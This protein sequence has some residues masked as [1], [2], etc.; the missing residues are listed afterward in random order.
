MQT[1]SQ[2]QLRHSCKAW[3]TRRD[4]QATG[5]AQRKDRRILGQGGAEREC[6]SSSRGPKAGGHGVADEGRR[7]SRPAVGAARPRR[8]RIPEGTWRAAAEARR[9]AAHTRERS[10]DDGR[11]LAS[12]SRRGRMSSESFANQ[13]AR[14]GRLASICPRRKSRR[15]QALPVRD[16]FDSA[17]MKTERAVERHRKNT[18][19]AFPN[20]TCE[21]AIAGFAGLTHQARRSTVRGWPPTAKTYASET[22][23]VSA[24]CL[25]QPPTLTHET[26]ALRGQLVLPPRRME[27]TSSAGARYL[28]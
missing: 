23:R 2:P 27:S 1:R 24:G 8:R 16:M 20:G 6:F 9:Q 4:L 10:L 19:R 28:A 11:S 21:L 13:P 22:S 26:H 3:A 18:R 7:R 5:I 12:T 25:R 15:T 14:E 17:G